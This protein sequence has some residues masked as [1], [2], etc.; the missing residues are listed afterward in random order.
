MNT[1]ARLMA[2]ERMYD[3][4]RI[5]TSREQQEDLGKDYATIMRSIVSLGILEG[6]KKQLRPILLGGKG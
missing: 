6:E 1:P 4:A 2:L 3:R 5:N